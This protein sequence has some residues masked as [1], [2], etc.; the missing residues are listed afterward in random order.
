MIT[1]T[2]LQGEPDEVRAVLQGLFAQ[3]SG[4]PV[5]LSNEALGSGIAPESDQPAAGEPWTFEE[6]SQYWEQMSPNPKTFFLEVAKHENGCHASVIKDKFGWD[7][8]QLAG[9]LTGPAAQLR[10]FPGKPPIY[11]REGYNNGHTYKVT[12]EIAG[13]IQRLNP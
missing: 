9:I 2:V 7:Y 8:R 4:N 12:L 13:F 11:T 3:S 1:V 6:F 10:R 5:L